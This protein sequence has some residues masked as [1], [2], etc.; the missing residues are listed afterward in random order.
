MPNNNLIATTFF[1]S[2]WLFACKQKLVQKGGMVLI[3]KSEN[4]GAYW[5]DKNL[6]S[7]ADFRKFIIATNYKT[8]AE[9]F[10]DAGFFEEKT[11][12]WSL[13][14]GANWQY[15]MGSD[16]PK[17]EDNHPVTQVSWQ[18]AVEYA[19][20]AGKRLPSKAE[21]DFAAKNAENS[22]QTYSWGENQLE[23]G[24]Y[25]ANF[26][27]GSFPLI[28][29]IKDGFKYTSPI[30]YFGETEVGLTDMGGNVWQWVED[31]SEE[32]PTEKLQ[33]GGSFLCDP[34]ICHGF[35]IGNTASSTPETSLMHIGFRCVK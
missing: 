24:K 29:T 18:D 15:P 31:W 23:A 10:G 30:G 34:N 11:G 35:K 7:V 6:V 2:I 32:K 3:P 27:Q 21:Y 26:W 33:V 19:K 22:E 1:I 20:W 4:L 25:K 5:I 12:E 8:D 17:A 13:K 16:F 9:K 14:K 28:N